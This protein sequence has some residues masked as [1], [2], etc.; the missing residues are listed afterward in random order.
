[1]RQFFPLTVGRPVGI[2]VAGFQQ[3]RFF[4]TPDMRI[5]RMNSTDL[6][7]NLQ[8][9]FTV[10]LVPH[11]SMQPIRLHFSMAILVFVAVSWTGLTLWSSFIASRHV[12]YWR[13]KANEQILR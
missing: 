10:M 4:D 3:S 1:M 8:R 11:N 2:Y 12:D 7:K 5:S 13:S 6:K 9:R